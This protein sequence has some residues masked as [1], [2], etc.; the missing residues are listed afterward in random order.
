MIAD[1]SSK[2]LQE[3]LEKVKISDPEP[4]TVNIETHVFLCVIAHVKWAIN[5]NNG[6]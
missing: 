1:D 2:T 4:D 6:Q 5:L 3:A